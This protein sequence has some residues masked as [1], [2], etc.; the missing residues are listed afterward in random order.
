MSNIIF[1]ARLTDEG[2]FVAVRRAEALLKQHGFSVGEM[3][4]GSSRGILFGNYDIQKWRNLSVDDIRELH[5]VLNG[6]RASNAR[7]EIWDPAPL[8]A[9]RALFNSLDGQPH[10]ILTKRPPQEFIFPELSPTDMATRY[11]KRIF[12]PYALR[13]VSHAE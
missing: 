10:T 3:Q 11:E 6:D 2:D 1:M 13:G 9:V 7:I 5:G 4:R 12:I 8:E